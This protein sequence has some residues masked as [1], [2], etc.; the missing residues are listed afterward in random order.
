VQKTRKLHD[1][2]EYMKTKEISNRPDEFMKIKEIDRKVKM[3]G[4]GKRPQLPTS[5]SPLPDR[6]SRVQVAEREDNPLGRRRVDDG[7]RS[8][9]P[10]ADG[11]G[12]RQALRS[13]SLAKVQY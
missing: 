2:D 3:S 12:D 5:G 7:E 6:P 4:L 10:S 1:P 11:S 13:V 9:S 8:V